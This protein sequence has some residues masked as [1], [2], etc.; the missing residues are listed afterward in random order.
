MRKKHGPARTAVWLSGLWTMTG[1]NGCLLSALKWRH[2]IFPPPPIRR[3]LEHTF[4][5]EQKSIEITL[6]SK[7]LA[8]LSQSQSLSRLCLSPSS[9]QIV[10]Q[11]RS[12]PHS[13]N[14][15][16]VSASLPRRHHSSA[17]IAAHSLPLSHAHLCLFASSL[18]QG[19][20]NLIY[21]FLLCLY[22]YILI[23]VW[24]F[25]LQNFSQS[26]NQ[27]PFLISSFILFTRYLLSLYF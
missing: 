3:H 14:H 7:T 2:F 23:F 22:I 19:K 24:C 18:S 25:F 12:L 20:W 16:L 15:S 27:Q 1:S 17:Q 10:A 5:H 9:T 13:L 21:A 4:N 26:I 6:N 8:S 11:P